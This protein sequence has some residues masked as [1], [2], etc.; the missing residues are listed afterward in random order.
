MSMWEL[1][2]YYT[3]FKFIKTQISTKNSDFDNIYVLF[4]CK[5]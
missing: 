3:I 1:Q 4:M 5:T 2:A